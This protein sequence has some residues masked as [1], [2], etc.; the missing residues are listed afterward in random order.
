TLQAPGVALVNE[1]FVR[2]YFPNQDP[3]GHHVTLDSNPGPLDAKDVYGVPVWSEIVG[4]IGD[5]KSLSTQPEPVPEIYRSYWQWPMQNPKLFIRGTGDAG[6]LTRAVRRETKTAIPNLPVPKIRL[7]TEHIDES[8]AQPRFQ[9]ELLALFAAVALLL[10]AFGI[11]GVLAYSVTQRYREIGVR[12]ALGAQMGNVL[13][14]VIRQGLKLALMGTLIGVAGALALTRVIRSLL[15]DV[16]PTDP[17]T[18]VTVIAT[19]WLVAL[20]A[21]WLPARR[22]AKVHPMEALR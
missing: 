16:T 1:S 18:F 20:L 3:L 10:A 4:V 6:A 7:L 8:V 19:L 5:V 13:L 17:I 14:L 21:C 15:Y 11:Y 2:R 22:A 12:I 9:A